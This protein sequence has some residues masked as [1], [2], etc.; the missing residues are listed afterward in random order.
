MRYRRDDDERQ[1]GRHEAHLGIETGAEDGSVGRR[2]KRMTKR[3][4]AQLAIVLRLAGFE[5]GKLIVEQRLP[6][7]G[8]GGR[9]EP[10]A[11]QIVRQQRAGCRLHDPRVRFVFR[12]AGDDADRDVRSVRRRQHRGDR[13][14]RRRAHG[15]AERVGIEQQAGIRT[16]GPHHQAR[17]VGSDR[18]LEIEDVVARHDDA[19]HARA[20]IR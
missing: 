7:R 8:P 12:A 19:R 9:T 15:L 14:M 3:D 20:G 18:T 4:R 6:I 10:R 11:G 17:V 16:V 5:F 1:I 13:K 2:A